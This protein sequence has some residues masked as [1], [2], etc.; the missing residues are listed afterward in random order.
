MIYIYI[1]IYIHPYT[2]TH[3]YTHTLLLSQCN[4]TVC[5]RNSWEHRQAWSLL[6]A[7]RLALNFALLGSMYMVSCIGTLLTWSNDSQANE[8][9]WIIMK[10]YFLVLCAYS[11]WRYITRVYVIVHACSNIYIYVCVCV[12][13]LHIHSCMQ[14][15]P[16]Y[17]EYVRENPHTMYSSIYIYI[18]IYIYVH[19]HK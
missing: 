6:P 18:Y 9:V 13:K 17:L 1:Y 11:K 19:T 3:I 12:C 10:K 7:S 4:L 2:Y 8:W 5:L 16:D 15:L 14:M